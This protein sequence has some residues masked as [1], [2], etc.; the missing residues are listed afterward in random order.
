MYINVCYVSV[1]MFERSIDNEMITA[2]CFYS[3]NVTI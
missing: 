3:E 2:Q 1:P